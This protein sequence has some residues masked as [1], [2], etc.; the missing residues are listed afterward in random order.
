MSILA[1]EKKKGELLFIFKFK[2]FFYRKR[3]LENIPIAKLAFPILKV[4]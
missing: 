2:K 3:I 1:K 4:Y